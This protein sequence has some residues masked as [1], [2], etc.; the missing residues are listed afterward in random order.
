MQFATALLIILVSLVSC[1]GQRVAKNPNAIAHEANFDLPDYTVVS[2][3]DNM[4]REASAWS[5]YAWTLKLKDSLSEKDIEKLNELVKKDSNWSYDSEKHIYKYNYDK[6]E[7][8]YFFIEIHIDT[9]VVNMEYNWYD[10]FA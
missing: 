5:S 6:P 10:I 3:S 9:G 7:S 1:G 8:K 2:Q 4:E